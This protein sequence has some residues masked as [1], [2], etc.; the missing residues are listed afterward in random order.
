MATRLRTMAAWARIVWS[1][2]TYPVILLAALIV[3]VFAMYYAASVALTAVESAV[4]RFDF[5]ATNGADY[6]QDELKLA[7][8]IVGVLIDPNT[9]AEV[10]KIEQVSAMLAPVNAAI[11]ADVQRDDALGQGQVLGAGDAA[12]APVGRGCAPGAPS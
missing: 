8:T 5:S 7:D 9:G 6:G 2:R 11:I 12:Q 10:V 3:T 1:N 4:F